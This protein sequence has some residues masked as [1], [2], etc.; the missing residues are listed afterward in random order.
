V[1][2]LLLLLHGVE[3]SKVEQEHEVVHVVLD[4]SDQ[5]THSIDAFEHCNMLEHG[6]K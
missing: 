2:L 4:G 5:Q 3:L 1:V 6:L